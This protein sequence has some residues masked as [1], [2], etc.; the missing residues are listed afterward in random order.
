MRASVY[1]CVC[2]G[3]IKNNFSCLSPRK[4]ARFAAESPHTPKIK[5][6]KKKVKKKLP[7]ALAVRIRHMLYVPRLTHTHTRTQ[8]LRLVRN[9]TVT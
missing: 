5:K 1:V 7:R 9:P 3:K 8:I 4:R 6:S 2:C